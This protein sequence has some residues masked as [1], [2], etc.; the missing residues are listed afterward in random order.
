MATAI[1]TTADMCNLGLVFRAIRSSHLPNAAQLRTVGSLETYRELTL[2]QF[3]DRLQKARL[4][5]FCLGRVPTKRG[6]PRTSKASCD[7]EIVTL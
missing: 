5:A 3:R 2:G 1:V 7:E 4:N 6:T